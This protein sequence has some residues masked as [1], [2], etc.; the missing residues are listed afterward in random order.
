MLKAMFLY[1]SIICIIIW[2]LLDANFAQVVRP[3][4]SVE[5]ANSFHPRCSWSAYNTPPEEVVLSQRPHEYLSEEDLPES[6]NW[7]DVNGV[8]YCSP[9]RN[10][11]IPV[12]CGSCWAMSGTSALA[13][14]D[15]IRRNDTS[16]GTYL[17]VQNVVDC[18]PGT[19]RYGGTGYDVYSYALHKGIPDETCHNYQAIDQSC[20][21]EHQ[22]YSCWPHGMGGCFAY[23]KKDYTRLKASEFGRVKGREHM[24]AEIFARGPIQCSIDAT[25]YLC[26]NY[27]GGIFA[28]YQKRPE[29]DHDISV[30]GWGVENGTEYWIIR[31]SWGKP[32]GEDG[33]FRL[34]TSKY[35]N[36]DG[37][38]YNLGIES[39]P[40]MWAV[41][42]AWEPANIAM[43]DDFDDVV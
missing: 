25:D 34:V 1:Y 15:N 13:D 4:P 23:D 14:R 6:W 27:T 41:P 30:V 43:G 35:M 24:M 32:W 9:M 31:N 42:K 11:H 18:T 36:G 3:P 28:E 10:Q 20:S 2:Q 33:F 19:C 40:C 22:C 16:M 39:V 17:S 7:C 38:H 26:L 37:N 8:N 21:A 29:Y 5:G 12:Y